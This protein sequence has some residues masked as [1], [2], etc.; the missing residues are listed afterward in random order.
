MC[1]YRH[2][3]VCLG[4]WWKHRYTDMAFHL[5][6]RCLV[7][8][9]L[10]IQCTIQSDTNYIKVL[11]RLPTSNILSAVHYVS[12]HTLLQCIQAMHGCSSSHL[13]IYMHAPTSS[14]E[15]STTFMRSTTFR[16]YILTIYK[17][18]DHRILALR[19]PQ[20]VQISA[21]CQNACMNRFNMHPPRDSSLCMQVPTE[22]NI[23]KRPR[24][25]YMIPGKLF[26]HAFENFD[27][28]YGDCYKY[29]M[30]TYAQLM[31]K[32]CMCH[33]S[34]CMS[35]AQF[36]EICTMPRSVNGWHSGKNFSMSRCYGPTT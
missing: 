30:L 3:C 20:I 33:C 19:M 24:G 8:H 26:G 1:I 31:E 36:R 11:G 15:T 34:L 13:I 28:S 18:L 5:K 25:L 2:V 16:S 35:L 29:A 32:Y 22:L 9:V 7:F 21:L 4:T 27:M 12:S 10:T 14:P 23:S 17:Q 6:M